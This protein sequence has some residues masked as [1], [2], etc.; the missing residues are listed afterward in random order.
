MTFLFTDRY[1]AGRYLATRLG[2]YAHS[3]RVLVLGLPRGGVPV[4]YEVARALD[5]PLEVFVVRKLGVPGQEELAMG[6]V[7]TGPVRV[8]N[9]AIVRALQITD[10]MLDRAT[11]R[12]TAELQRREREYRGDR[13]PP[14][15]QGQTVMLIDDG[16]ATGASM[17]AAATALRQ[18]NPS[19]IVVAV[20]IAAA[21]TCA[22]LEPLVDE[23]VCAT[24]PEPFL[25]VGRWYED[26][27]QMTDEQ[28]R[29]LL[30]RA[31]REQEANVR[32]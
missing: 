10:E 18:Q 19:R 32:L 22:E 15:V 31:W 30:Q 3:P 8:L 13:P 14:Q 25:G 29:E 4:A 28:V 9:H 26:F 21:D 7:A 5:A 27:S 16:L 17:R 20:P 11:R 23:I 1:D 2:H 24:M 6:A 12:E